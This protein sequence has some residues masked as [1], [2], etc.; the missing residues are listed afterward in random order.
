M[1]KYRVDYAPSFFEDMDKLDKGTSRQIA[2][3]IDKHLV[4]VDFP[5]SP[6]KYLTGNLAGYVRFRVGNYRIIAVVD[7]GELVLLNL[8]VGH[9][10]D[11]YKKLK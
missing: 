1:A 8:H 6:G 9:R 4:D 5:R 3:W 7:E 2:R 11:I 10:S